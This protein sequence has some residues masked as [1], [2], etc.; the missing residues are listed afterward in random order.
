MNREIS[1][2]STIKLN[3]RL[4]QSINKAA[5]VDSIRSNRRINTDD[6]KSAESS[7]TLLTVTISIAKATLYRFNSASEKLTVGAAI[8][9]GEFENTIMSSAGLKPSFCSWHGYCSCAET[10]HAQYKLKRCSRAPLSRLVSQSSEV[11]KILMINLSAI[12][13]RVGDA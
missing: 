5:I 11:D 4:L 9:F 8:S 7:L 13:R 10:R 12:S 6:P 3:I 2:N 1:E